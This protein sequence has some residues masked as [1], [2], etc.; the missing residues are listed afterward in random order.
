MRRLLILATALLLA[1]RMG[2]A[3][4]VPIGSLD[5]TFSKDGIVQLT[6]GS[7]ADRVQVDAQNRVI[8]AGSDANGRVVLRYKANGALDATWKKYHLQPGYGAI[9]GL[10][11]DGSKVLISTD[12][13]GTNKGGRL[14]RLNSN[15]TL[16]SSFG[17][18]GVMVN[19]DSFCNRCGLNDVG[20]TGNGVIFATAADGGTGEGNVEGTLIKVS[21]DGLTT[22]AVDCPPNINSDAGCG[23]THALTVT[24][25]Y[26][27]VAG[28]GA[29]DAHPDGATLVARY[30]LNGALDTSYGTGGYAWLNDDAYRSS[31]VDIA[32]A[33]STDEATVIG[34]DCDSSFLCTS[35][36]TRLDAVG[37]ADSSFHGTV[38][39]GGP[40]PFAANALAL[41]S[42]GVVIVG[43]ASCNNASVECFG[44][45]RLTSTGAL[46]T[47]FAG[48][49]YV[50]TAK[51]PAAASSVRIFNTKIVVAGG[52]YI[53]R[54]QG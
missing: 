20:V 40:G 30:S 35:F 19:P 16:D 48:T 50:H 13:I 12:G 51:A 33:P 11:L 42:G 49:G 24:P 18:G 10:V 25:S 2:A 28:A 15:G 53:A 29:D 43:S 27:Y 9:T 36:V 52:Q 22:T 26:V 3:Q 31:L 17:V 4:A 37:D 5:P 6:S 38:N 21:A 45:E 34:T 44:V 8:A 23:A 47:N 39:F 14:I 1:A 32:V 7:L 41:Q 54:Y 46:D